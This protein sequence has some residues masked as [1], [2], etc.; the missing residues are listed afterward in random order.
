MSADQAEGL[1]GWP[2]SWY[3]N[4]NEDGD[5]RCPAVG[6]DKVFRTVEEM[7]DRTDH[8]NDFV[9]NPDTQLHHDVLRAINNVEKCP[10]CDYSE[11]RADLDHSIHDT[12]NLFRHERKVHHSEELSDI[13]KFIGLIRKHR[14]DMFG[15]GIHIWPGLHEYYIRNILKQPELPELEKYLQKFHVDTSRTLS[16]LDYIAAVD[17][18]SAFP[19]GLTKEQKKICREYYP[20]DRDRFL[21][22]F[23]PPKD[24]QMGVPHVWDVM[25]DKYSKGEF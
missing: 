5:L 9:E 15:G 18:G 25:R 14:Y 2:K 22:C 4:G 24:R 16:Y 11:K 8:L 23:G 6:C 17:R 21:S 13:K 10:K 3:V 19:E 12:R 1:K 20:V 7:E